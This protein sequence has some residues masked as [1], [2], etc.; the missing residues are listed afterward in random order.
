VEDFYRRFKDS[1][2]VIPEKVKLAHIFK[3]PATSAD[4]KEK[5]RKFASELLDS[6]NNGM[7]FAELA[8][9]YSDDPGSAVQGGDLGFVKRGMFFSEFEAAA[10]ALQTNQL[11][12]VIESPVGFHII[13]LLERRGESIHTRHI[14]IKIKSDDETDYKVIETLL[15]IKDSIQLGKATFAEF[16]KKH[17]DDEETSA[18]GGALGTF[19]LEQLDKNLLDIAMKLQDG[20]I[21]APKRV[22]YQQG[23]YGYHIVY[24]ESRIKQHQADMEIDFTDLK[25]LAEEYKKQQLYQKWID[26]LKT[27]IFWEIKS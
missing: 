26:E 8:K 25:R 5:F 3:N 2:G 17:S 19:Y 15:A 4:L 1:L 24:L 14:L 13:Q 20:E 22:T 18:F 23:K 6:I 16:A 27:K 12:P 21:S 9:K 11:S 10:Y 7:D